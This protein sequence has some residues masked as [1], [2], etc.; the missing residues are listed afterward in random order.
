MDFKTSTLES[1]LIVNEFQEVFPDKLPSVPPEREI[2]FYIDFLPD[3]ETI[4]IIPFHV[5]PTK[6]KDLND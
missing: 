5:D 2:N 6:H 4:Y 3:K 1:V